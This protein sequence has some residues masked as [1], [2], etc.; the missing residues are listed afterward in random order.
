M[1]RTRTLFS[2]VLGLSLIAA[3]AA[4]PAE[5]AGGR[6]GPLKVKLTAKD[7]RRLSRL[8]ADHRAQIGPHRTQTGITGFTPVVD[9]HIAEA[10]SQAGV[11]WKKLSDPR[12]GTKGP[13]V[14]EV[15]G[16]DQAGGEV[17]MVLTGS[18]SG[19]VMNPHWGGRPFAEV[20][21]Y[22]DSDTV[23]LTHRA[24]GAR[25]TTPV[26]RIKSQG[27]VTQE[28]FSVNLSEKGTHDFFYFRTGANGG[29]SGGE[30]SEPE[31]RHVQ[32]IVK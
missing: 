3:A 1:T 31:L 27:F 16:I 2:F 29:G 26:V 10:S 30:G 25:T 21:R 19:H 9:L 8:K 28:G 11:R 15:T 24:P 23:N 13:T 20:Q 7:Q 32:I 4:T 6:V 17:N 22:A 5:A 12:T 14:F 18:A